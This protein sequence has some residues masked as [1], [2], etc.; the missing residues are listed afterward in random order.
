MQSVSGPL[1]LNTAKAVYRE[2]SS[3]AA[4]L[5]QPVT[6]A[7]VGEPGWFGHMAA[8]QL[9]RACC[10]LGP[11]MCIQWLTVLPGMQYGRSTRLRSYESVG[12]VFASVASGHATYG[13]VAVENTSAGPVRETMSHLQLHNGDVKICAETYVGVSYCVCASEN[14]MAVDITHVYTTKDVAAQCRR[15]GSASVHPCC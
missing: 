1:N 9:V 2:V 10:L 11:R 7:Y 5:V 12:D 14:V 3:A 6:V 15:Y 13:V 8:L 4:S